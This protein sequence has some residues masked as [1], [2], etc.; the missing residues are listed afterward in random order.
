MPQYRTELDN[1]YV[2][3]VVET[4][5]AATAAY[6]KI[7][8]ARRLAEYIE[9]HPQTP[10]IMDQRTPLDIYEDGHKASAKRYMRVLEAA[11][12]GIRI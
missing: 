11:K 12:H 5:L 8:D 7:S 3:R 4:A 2:D 1:E 10:A 9:Q 6:G